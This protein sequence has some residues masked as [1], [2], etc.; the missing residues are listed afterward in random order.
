MLKK[1]QGVV[2]NERQTCLKSC[3]LHTHKH[4]SGTWRCIVDSVSS[5]DVIKVNMTQK[6][7]VNIFISVCFHFTFYLLMFA[8]FMFMSCSGSPLTVGF[9]IL[10]II[11]LF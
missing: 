7:V 5:F 4:F 3:L 9:V 2:A 1:I 10:K 6:E 8:V 11:D